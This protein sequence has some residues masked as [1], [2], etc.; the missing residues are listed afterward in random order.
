MAKKIKETSAE[1]KLR[2]LYDLQII[3]SKIDRIREVR[4]ELPLEVEDLEAEISGLDLRLEKITDEIDDLKRQINERKSGIEE[5]KALIAKYTEQQN[6]VRNNREFDSITKEIEF[7]NLE[8]ELSDKRIKEFRYKIESKEAIF[9]ESKL[10]LDERKEVLA[11]KKAEL[12]SIS[13]ETRKEEDILVEESENS[14]QLVDP[15]LLRAYKRIRSSAKN[16]LAVVPV[17]RGA[18]AGS[19]IQIPPQVQIDIAARKKVII[20]EHSGRILV[21][22]ELAIEEVDKME[23]KIAKLLK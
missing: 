16:G 18:S 20:D 3:D 11:N 4:G 8:I 5:S 7:Q 21:D 10:V 13:S 1:E 12:E 19:F 23:K 14:A 6:K 9:A 2:L 15:R 22:S 17:E